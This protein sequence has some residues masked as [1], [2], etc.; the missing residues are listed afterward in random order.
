MAT[1]AIR[2]HHVPQECELHSGDRLS[3]PEFHRRY[4]HYPSDVKFELI[5]G[6]VFMAAAQ[7]MPHG[8][9]WLQLSAVL[10][11]YVL[12]TPGV[13][14]STNSSLLLDDE[15][16]PQPDLLLRI[17][18]SFGGQTT[19]DAEQYLHGAPELVIEVAHSTA[20]IDLHAK[21]IVYQRH[22][23][24]EY[25]VVC[26]SERQVRWFDLTKR[27][28][29]ALDAMGV[30][31]SRQFP[32]LWLA[33]RELI[34]GETKAYRAVARRGLKSPEHKAFVEELQKRASELSGPRKLATR[35]RR[36]AKRKGR[37]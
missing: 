4:Q 5:E 7:R 25:I 28:E 14:G 6:T 8:N 1:A 18:E 33:T 20:A 10:A 13:E 22:G 3:R 35:P 23:V 12:A 16:E 36:T 32:G 9:Y 24:R 17:E 30:L 31:K 27:T 15:N 21:R 11:D 29:L 19:L 2:L 37:S 26:V 34:A